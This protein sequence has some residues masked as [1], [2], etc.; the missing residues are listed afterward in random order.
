VV[1]TPAD[2]QQGQQQQEKSSSGPQNTPAA[3]ADVSTPVGAGADGSTPA[4][5]AA[6]AAS[7]GVAAQPASALP[8][9]LLQLPRLPGRACCSLLA[10]AYSLL[11]TA[12][13][14]QRQ[15]QLKPREQNTP[16]DESGSQSHAGPCLP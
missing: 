4:A 9:W 5:T 11:Q 12:L 7:A 2:K 8:V 3:I 15:Q 6:A 16:G 14:T 13:A 1:R 10:A